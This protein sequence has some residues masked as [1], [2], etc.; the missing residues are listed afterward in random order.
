MAKLPSRRRRGSYARMSVLF[1]A[2]LLFIWLAAFG[3]ASWMSM[4]GGLL[5]ALAIEWFFPLPHQSGTWHIRPLRL[6]KLVAKFLWDLIRSGIHVAYL[7]LVPKQREDAIIRCDVRSINPVY[8]SVL[9][10]MTSLIPGTIVVQ[11]DRPHKR[12]F[13]HVLDLQHQGGAEGVRQ[14]VHAQETRILWA[15]A[16]NSVL[17]ETGEKEGEPTHG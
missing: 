6:L 12:I 13:L 8:I 1:T 7:V 5:V 2:W 14:A 10:A 4:A 3:T 16:P 15:I 17:I 11:V 9:V